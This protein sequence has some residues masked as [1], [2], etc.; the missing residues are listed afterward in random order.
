MFCHPV[1]LM[2]CWKV[3]TFN[4]RNRVGFAKCE[5]WRIWS[6][7]KRVQSTIFGVKIRNINLFCVP[8]IYFCPLKFSPG[9]DGGMGP[10]LVVAQL[11][12]GEEILLGQGHVHLVLQRLVEDAGVREGRCLGPFSRPNCL[13]HLLPSTSSGIWCIFICLHVFINWFSHLGVFWSHHMSLKISI[14]GFIWSEQRYYCRESDAL[15][16][17]CQ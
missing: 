5:L 15:I 14:V 9:R 12:R 11:H 10:R 16:W 13:S 17:F 4:E 7:R 8:T 6:H 3:M 1:F 2:Q